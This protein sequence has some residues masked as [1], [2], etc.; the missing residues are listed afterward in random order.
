MD[1]EGLADPAI[2]G[3]PGDETPFHKGGR[4]SIEIQPGGPE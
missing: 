1:S 2:G 3:V 4:P